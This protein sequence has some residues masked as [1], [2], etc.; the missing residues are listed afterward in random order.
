MIKGILKL[1]LVIFFLGCVTESRENFKSFDYLP[2]NSFL[3]FKVNEI[4]QIKSS[5]LLTNIFSIEKDYKERFNLLLPTFNSEEILFFFTRIGK[6]KDAISFISNINETDTIT[7]YNEKIMYSGIQIGINEQ[8]NKTKIYVSN[9]DSFKI[10]SESKLVI[11]DCIRNYLNKKKGI[12]DK[13]FNELTQIMDNESNVNI[14]I[15]PQAK[16][17]F[18][19]FFP[20]VPI[21]PKTGN[22]WIGLDMDFSSDIFSLNGIGFINDSIP[23]FLDLI[24][25]QKP[26]RINIPEIIPNNFSSY[27]GLTIENIQQLEENFKKYSIKSNLAIKKIDFSAISDINE[28]GWLRQ[29]ENK[30]VIF[31]SNNIETNRLLKYTSGNEKKFRSNIYYSVKLPIEIENFLN[32]SGEK[33]DLKWLMQ[34][35][36][37]FIISE[38]ESLVKTIFSNYKNGSTLS[39]DNNFKSLKQSLSNDNSFIWIGNTSKLIPKWS[40]NSYKKGVLK[41]I[42]PKQFPLIA[43]QGIIEEKYSHL[44]FKIQK[45]LP[46]LKKNTAV[47][48]YNLSLENNALKPPKWIKNHRTKEMDIVIQDNQNVLYL[49]SNK[50]KLLWK[51][52]LGGKILGDI[53]QVDLYK[54]KRLQMVFRTN[55]RFL[56]LD[57]NGEIV[58]PFNIKLE[59]N[60]SSIPL[61]VFDYD[62]NRNYRFLVV[63]NSSTLM[64]DSKGKKV[65]GFNSKSI[66]ERITHPPKHI[67]ISGKD[68]LIFKH[69][70]GL[71]ILN[72]KGQN[73]IKLKE[74]ISFS[75]NT[76]FSYLD[77]F[78]TTDKEGNLVQIDAKGNVFLTKLDLGDN[79]Y[80]A[81]TTKSLV[82]F[83]ENILTIKGIPIKLPFGNYTRPKIFYINNTLY[84]SITDLQAQKVYL[85]YSNGS[86][87]GGFPVY[88]TSEADLSNADKDKS[89]EL[90]VL[91][92]NKEILIYQINEN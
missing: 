23:N 91:S 83:S 21:F 74:N 6:N 62:S 77:T 27:L 32:L 17:I 56:I 5:S 38:N 52:K 66:K 65:T 8:K 24:K 51:K 59:K 79:H 68:Y 28:I 33:T 44:H 40:E 31:H 48:Q 87:V 82:T 11:E 1:F 57:R 78:M 14:F 58:K 86:S 75:N 26:T 30:A 25:G 46:K 3:V 90:T 92:G 35:D 80:I 69:E 53:K 34:L 16:K 42:N 15:H 67:R 54:N 64:Y 81:S 60:D 50:G 39:R 10:V 18:G 12:V 13:R 36:S 43:M 55:D 2:Q 47:N 19:K 61:S 85:Y 63:N 7:L 88:G 49:F 20:Y 41:K 70:N 71:K 37:F 29:D 76:I 22:E 72:R 84:I 73:R 9:I 4:S 45:N 89:I